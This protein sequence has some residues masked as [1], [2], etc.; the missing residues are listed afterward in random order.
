[1]FYRE[2][3]LRCQK[4]L[5]QQREHYSERAVTDVETALAKVIAQLDQLSTRDDGDQVI[6]RLLQ[7]FDVVT[8]LSAWTDPRQ[9][10]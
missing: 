8:G 2:E 7:Q 6:S 3:F 4:Y 5:N 9:I 10:N 1:M